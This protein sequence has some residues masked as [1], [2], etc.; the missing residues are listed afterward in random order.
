MTEQRIELH[1]WNRQL[2]VLYLFVTAQVESSKATTCPGLH[3]LD[4]SRSFPLQ[5]AVQ[6]DWQGTLHLSLRIS[7]KGTSKPRGWTTVPG[8]TV[9]TPPIP[10]QFHSSKEGKFKLWQVSRGMQWDSPMGVEIT[11]YV[12]KDHPLDQRPNGVPKDVWND[13]M[14]QLEIPN[15]VAVA[16]VT[17]KEFGP[18]DFRFEVKNQ[19]PPDFQFGSTGGDTARLGPMQIDL[20]PVNLDPPLLTKQGLRVK[21][22]FER[23]AYDL[24]KNPRV[25]EPDGVTRDQVAQLETFTRDMLSRWDVRLGLASRTLKIHAHARAS[26]TFKTEN[27]TGAGQHFLNALDYNRDLSEK[28]KAAVIKQLERIIAAVDKDPTDSGL[29]LPRHLDTTEMHA[30]GMLPAVID[31]SRGEI[32]EDRVCD[33]WIEADELKEALKEV[34]ARKDHRDCF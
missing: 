21:V 32:V 9:A 6:P 19:A 2:G 28:R 27:Q 10:L 18:T 23:D 34:F 30:T 16:D 8:G 13:W 12:S 25:K 3:D 4:F 5:L 26:A 29:P 15:I 22:Y 7:Y 33:I 14:Q 17:L 31:P 1:D 11:V 24:E 20:Q